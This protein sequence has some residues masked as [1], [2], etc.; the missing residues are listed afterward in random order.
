MALDAEVLQAL[1]P[2]ALMATPSPTVPAPP[3]QADR[4][5]GTV[6]HAVRRALDAEHCALIRDGHGDRATN[7]GFLARARLHLH[8]T[9]ATVPTIASRPVPPS[10]G[11]E[12]TLVVEWADGDRALHNVPALDGLA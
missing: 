1:L 5:L 8:D 6:L 4:F 10:D 9:S 7:D 11:A 2:I 3:R 12:G